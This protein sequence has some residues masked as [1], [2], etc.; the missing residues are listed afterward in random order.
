MGRRLYVF[1]DES[2]NHSRRDC[3][4][5]AGCW[6]FSEIDDA[7]RILKPTKRR[8]ASNVLHDDSAEV[9]GA[10]VDE[11]TLSTLLR[12]MENVLMDDQSI[13]LYNFPWTSRFPIAYTFYDSDSDVGTRI[14]EKHLGESARGT[15]PQLIA[16]A[17]V[18]SPLLRIEDQ[19]AGSIESYHV[20]LDATTWERPRYTLSMIIE[21]IDWSP[22][23]NFVTRDSK[24]VP[25][26]QLADVGAN[27]RRRRLRNGPSEDLE[28]SLSALWL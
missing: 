7:S 11:G 21:S 17:S 18:V 1:V 3:Y 19:V 22:D 2:G 4:V 10:D 25:G 28:R 14:A 6:C 12:Y 16:L 13:D 9:K 26:L 20:V 15:T 24:A 8:I 5:V 23:V 27:A